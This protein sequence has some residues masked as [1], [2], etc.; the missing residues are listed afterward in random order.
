[1]RELPLEVI[2]TFVRDHALE[3]VEKTMHG[4]EYPQL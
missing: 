3:Q 2:H 4:E 1:M